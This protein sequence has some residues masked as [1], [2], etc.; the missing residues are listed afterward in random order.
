MDRIRDTKCFQ[1]ESPQKQESGIPDPHDSNVLLLNTPGK[2]VPQGDDPLK[3]LSELEDTPKTSYRKV[4]LP[5]IKNISS[6]NSNL[7]VIFLGFARYVEAS[8]QLLADDLD[9]F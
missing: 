6:Y 8:D 3:N 4:L 7:A 9:R 2:K 5:Y 1:I